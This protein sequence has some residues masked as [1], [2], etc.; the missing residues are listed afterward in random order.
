MLRAVPE[1]DR[2]AILRSASVRKG[3]DFHPAGQIVELPDGTRRFVR[4]PVQVERDPR[5]R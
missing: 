2:E 3:G 1:T 4:S 5:P